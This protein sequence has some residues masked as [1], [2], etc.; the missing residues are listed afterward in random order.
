MI[1]VGSLKNSLCISCFF[2]GVLVCFMSLKNNELKREKQRNDQKLY[3]LM[4]PGPTPRASSI[5]K[6]LA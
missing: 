1:Y 6:Y 3:C 2:V 4:Q 5:I